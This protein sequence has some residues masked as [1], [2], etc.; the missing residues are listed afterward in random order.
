MK[1]HRLY[2]QGIA[3]V[4]ALVYAV[5]LWSDGIPPEL[6]WLRVY[7]MAVLIAILLWAAWDRWIWRAPL[8]QR[9]QPIPP[10][11]IG[12]W[13]GELRSHWV[14]PA[15]KTNP[16]HKDVYLVIKQTFSSVSVALFT[17]ESQSQS[18]SVMAKVTK[19]HGLSYLYLNEPEMTASERS[20][21]HRG[22]AMFRLSGS[23]VDTMRGR[24]WT[25]RDTKGELVFK[26]RRSTHA[27]DY[28]AATV[29]FE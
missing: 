9:L 21:M 17:E 25:D 2:I 26:E 6:K 11:I 20:H 24:Y 5:F 15:T 19:T 27:D 22:A 28:A 13:K 8:F 7:S 18:H 3:G 1:D 14:D 12:T 4:V 29:L 23:P 10:N 16:P